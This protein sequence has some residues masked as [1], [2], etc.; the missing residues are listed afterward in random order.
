M[1]KLTLLLRSHHF[2]PI[3]LKWELC[4]CISQ[5]SNYHKEPG[6]LEKCQ[7]M[8]SL[9][10]TKEDRDLIYL[11]SHPNKKET[12]KWEKTLVP[13]SPG[14]WLQ[15][16]SLPFSGF[17]CRIYSFVQMNTPKHL[18]TFWN[19]QLSINLVLLAPR[20]PRGSRKTFIPLLK[21][22]RDRKHTERQTL[23]SNTHSP[24][25]LFFFSLWLDNISHTFPLDVL[26]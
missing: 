23:F 22:K 15:V 24:K 18:I 2:P 13:S 3:H 1:G 26:K 10:A 25:H 11:C 19:P 16:Y 6:K 14:T 7:E 5:E 9:S 4:R 21:P 12:E 8:W 20:R 17:S